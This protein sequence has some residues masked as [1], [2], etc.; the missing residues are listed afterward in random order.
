MRDGSKGFEFPVELLRVCVCVC[1][2]V[3]NMSTANT[4]SECHP[5]KDSAAYGYED[6]LW[7]QFLP[8]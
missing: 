3:V 1:D 2:S 4:G 5:S 6:R 8:Q 7:R